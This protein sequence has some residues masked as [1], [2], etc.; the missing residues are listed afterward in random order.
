MAKLLLDDLNPLDRAHVAAL[1]MQPGWAV[2]VKM[3]E[4]ACQI[5]ITQVIL[6][7][8]EDANYN[9]KL[10]NAQINARATNDFCA[11]I[12]KSIAAHCA[13]MGEEREA[14]KEE[15]ENAKKVIETF[16]NTLQK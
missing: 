10:A 3:F 14:E 4:Q 12:L 13:A 1:T 15:I 7:S 6:L 8:P 5:A 9:Q 2:V 16:R 11:S